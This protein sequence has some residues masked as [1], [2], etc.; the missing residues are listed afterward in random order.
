MPHLGSCETVLRSRVPAPPGA[1]ADGPPGGGGGFRPPPGPSTDAFGLRGER[2]AGAP[3]S[4]ARDGMK[5]AAG[6]SALAR[7]RGGRAAGANGEPNLVVRPLPGPWVHGRPATGARAH[8]WG[9]AAAGGPCGVPPVSPVGGPSPRGAPRRRRSVPDDIAIDRRE[10]AS[11][12]PGPPRGT[13][14]PPPRRPRGFGAGAAVGRGVGATGYGDGVAQRGGRTP[15][16]R[17]LWALRGSHPRPTGGVRARWA[18]GPGRPDP[19]APRGG[20]GR[21]ARGPG[22]MNRGARGPRALGGTVV[23]GSGRLTPSLRGHTRG[24]ALKKGTPLAGTLGPPG[25]AWGASPWRDADTRRTR[26]HVTLHSGD[27]LGRFRPVEGFGGRGRARR[28]AREGPPAVRLR[29]SGSVGT[30]DRP[31][32]DP[33]ASF[34]PAWE[35]ASDGVGALRGPDA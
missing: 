11:L 1:H 33:A 4:G 22:P 31:V 8:G 12:G 10:A 24:E 6:P 32:R 28:G 20:G 3:A 7:P 9:R 27:T 30:S 17:T 35:T 26:S 15:T 5:A 13:R 21:G 29:P 19:P 25:G 34:R 16:A 18:L 14:P 23:A 2:A